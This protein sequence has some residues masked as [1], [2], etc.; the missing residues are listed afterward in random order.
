MLFTSQLTVML[1][2]LDIMIRG[3]KKEREKGTRAIIFFNH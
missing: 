1:A 2:M 3:Y